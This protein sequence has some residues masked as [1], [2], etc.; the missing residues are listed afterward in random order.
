MIEARGGGV[1]LT[2]NWEWGEGASITVMLTLSMPMLGATPC[3]NLHLRKALFMRPFCSTLRKLRL[4]E[5]K[6][7]GQGD[8]GTK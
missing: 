1:G 2:C 5:E 7:L 4:R 3:P 6:S 8:A